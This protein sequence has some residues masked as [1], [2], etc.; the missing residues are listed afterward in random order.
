MFILLFALACTT[1]KPSVE[2]PAADSPSVD[3]TPETGEGGETAH[4]GETGAAGPAMR[5]EPPTGGVMCFDCHLCADDETPAV[6]VTHPVCVSCHKGPDGSVPDEV[7]SGCGCGALDCGTTPPTLGCS[8]CHVE[9]GD[10][11]YESSG[12]MN[13]LCLACHPHG[14]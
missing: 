3:S 13:D 2:Q 8:D 11:G 12:H 1:P 7:Q 4:T 10:N 9:A 6:E 5:H 14:Q